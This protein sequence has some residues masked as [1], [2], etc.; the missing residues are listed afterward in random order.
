M[1]LPLTPVRFLLR[2][3]EEYGDKVGIVDGDRR[4]TYKEVLDRAVRLGA[5]LRSL[6]LEPGGRVATL[7]FNC[8]Q[9]LEAYYGVPIARGVLL[10]LN[11]RLS[12]EE[13]AYILDH[14][15]ARIVLF[16]PEFADLCAALHDQRADLIWVALMDADGLPDWVHPNNYEE[17]LSAADP[18][19]LD[20]TT[21]DETAVAELFY[22]SGSTGRPKGVMLSHRTLYLHCIYA[23]AGRPAARDRNRGGRDVRDAHPSP[24]FTPTAGD[25]LTPSPSRE[26]GTSSSSASIPRKSVNLSRK[27]A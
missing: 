21:Y 13:Q 5:A 18:Q 16:D 24:F 1:I 17:L 27:S 22:T 10:S 3:A 2:A 11:V 23:L 20:F 26:A 15:G 9:L 8:H 6:G 14:S 12:V 4:L 25:V 19:P 7:S